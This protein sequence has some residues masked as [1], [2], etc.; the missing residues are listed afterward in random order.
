MRLTAGNISFVFQKVAL[1][2]P[3][4][5]LPCPQNLVSFSKNTDYWTYSECCTWEHSQGSVHRA[6]GGVGLALRVLG[7]PVEK[8]SSRVLPEAYGPTFHWSPEAIIRVQVPLIFE[9]LS[10]SFPFSPH[11]PCHRGLSS[12]LWG[13][14]ERNR[15]LQPQPTQLG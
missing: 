9:I 13:L 2:F 15:F 5:L 6:S 8:C 12:V 4:V 10:A 1:W 3:F 7:L 14:L 11:C